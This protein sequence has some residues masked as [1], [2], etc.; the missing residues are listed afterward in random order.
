[1]VLLVVLEDF[2]GNLAMEYLIIVFEIRR[3]MK[4]LKRLFTKQRHV[5]VLYP[6][7]DQTKTFAWFQ[8]AQGNQFYVVED[9]ILRFFPGHR[10]HMQCTRPIYS[11][12]FEGSLTTVKTLRHDRL[13]NAMNSRDSIRSH[14]AN[15]K[16]WK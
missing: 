4:S 2:V 16:S 14:V 6:V 5:N 8:T 7:N 3:D 13:K 1:M 11:R 12:K 10:R 15:V 9:G